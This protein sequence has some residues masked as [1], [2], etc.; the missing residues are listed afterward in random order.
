MPASV[1]NNSPAIQ[2]GLSIFK[3]EKFSVRGGIDDNGEPWFV[4]S[5]VARDLGYKRPNDAVNAHAR[6]TAERRSI[7]D[8]LGRTQEVRIIREPDVY[9]LIFK[10]ELETAQ[11]FEDWVVSEVLPSIRKTGGYS[12]QSKQED[13][14]QFPI[15]QTFAEALMLAANQAAQIEHQK[16]RIVEKDAQIAEMREDVDALDRIAGADGLFGLREAVAMLQT[17]QNKFVAW[18]QRNGWAYRQT[19][20]KRLLAYA[21]KRKAGYATN[22]ARVYQKPD[23]SEGVDETLKFTPA[24][25]VKLA[26]LLSVTLTDADLRTLHGDKGRAA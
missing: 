26:K 13:A 24:G 16:T 20:S 10:S 18:L 1:T 23:G 25:I 7:V 3:N 21:D 11:E 15:P 4:A 2:S 6:G 22:K 8:A 12:V 9:R 14:P 19:G 17:S 5:D